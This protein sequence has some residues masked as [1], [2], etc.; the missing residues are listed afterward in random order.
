MAVE[1]VGE[2]LVVVSVITGTVSF[3]GLFRRLPSLWLPTR[4]RAIRVWVLSF[5]LLLVG[6]SLLPEPPPTPTA[7]RVEEAS[8]RPAVAERDVRPELGVTVEEF[9]ARYNQSLAAMD[10]GFGISVDRE[11]DNGEFLTVQL[12]STANVGV[13]ATANNRTRSLQDLTFIGSG[14]GDL[15]SGVDIIFGAAAVV[16]ALEDPLMPP[17]Q[18]GEILG[19]L[20]LTD[21]EGLSEEGR[22]TIRNGVRY[23]LS[24]SDVLGVMLVVERAE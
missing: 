7:S 17:S 8:P 2:L 13:V 15:S 12:S 19:D 16:M 21:G 22:E 11:V 23:A 4:T 14:T 10:A 20:G 5:L 18:R 3:I 1:T 9:V 6:S 24:Q